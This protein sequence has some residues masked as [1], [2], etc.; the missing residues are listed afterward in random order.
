MKS[1]NANHTKLYRNRKDGK[2]AG[3]CAGIADY[4]GWDVDVVRILTVVGALFFTLPA[5]ILYAGAALLLPEQPESLYR[6]PEEERYWKRYRQSPRD[7]LAET[8][9]RFL[10]LEQRLRR[11]EAYATS[12]R[13][14]L[15]RQFKRIDR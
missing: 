5:L 12:K 11:I 15:D 14:D 3:V 6:E 2:I 1:N 4:F 8:K 13:F 7:T 9:Q 10:R